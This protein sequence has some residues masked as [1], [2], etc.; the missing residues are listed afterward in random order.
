MTGYLAHTFPVFSW[1][2]Y[3]R[4]TIKLYTI[5]TVMS[6]RR[7]SKSR[8][9]RCSSSYQRD[10]PARMFEPREEWPISHW[11]HRCLWSGVTTNRKILLLSAW[12]LCLF[13]RYSQQFFI[14]PAVDWSFIP[15]SISYIL[16]LMVTNQWANFYPKIENL[17]Y[18][19]MVLSV[20]QRWCQCRVDYWFIQ[21]HVIA[22]SMRATCGSTGSCFSYFQNSEMQSAINVVD[23][24]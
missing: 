9:R 24:I 12:Y 13:L 11:Y 19:K 15:E 10:V 20:I 16:I 6:R 5:F 8:I 17:F 22:H 18:V 3:R 14:A 23:L 1:E 7:M 4:T 2:F 21:P